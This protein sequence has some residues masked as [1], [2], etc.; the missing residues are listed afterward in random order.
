MHTPG[1]SLKFFD[2]SDLSGDA[3]PC[4]LADFLG[5]NQECPPDESE[6]E[7]LRSCPVAGTVN[8]GIGG[9]FVT[10]RRVS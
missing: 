8:L 2:L 4:S 7:A 5:V 6:V 10:V 1:D 9:G 3:E